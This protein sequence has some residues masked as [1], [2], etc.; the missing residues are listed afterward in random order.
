MGVDAALT[1]ALIRR[2]I[3]LLLAGLGLLGMLKPGSNN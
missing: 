2:L 3:A 1:L